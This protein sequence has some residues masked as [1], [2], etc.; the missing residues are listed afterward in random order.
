MEALLPFSIP[1]RGLN[2]GAHSYEFLIEN[3]FFESFEESPIR[4]ATINLTLELE[5]RPDMYEFYFKFS[6]HFKTNCDRCLAGI[7]LPIEG[8]ADLLGKVVSEEKVDD[9][10][11]IYITPDTQKINVATYIYEFIC[12]AIPIVKIFD[13][14]GVNPRPC[15]DSTLKFLEQSNQ[16]DKG[17]EQVNPIWEQLKGLKTNS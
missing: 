3:E 6:G 7:D 17:T 1:I 5:K 15:D 16:E 14:D 12:L 10:E 8:T 4:E 11:V 9:P 13:C 2:N